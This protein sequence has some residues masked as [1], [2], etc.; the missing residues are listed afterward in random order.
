MNRL[1]VG[2]FTFAIN[3]IY[4]DRPFC[5]FY[6][7][8]TVGRVSYFAL[9]S[10]LDFYETLGWR[11]YENRLKIHFAESW[12]E[13]HHILIMEELSEDRTWRD[14]LFARLLALFYYWVTVIVYLVNPKSAHNLVELLEEFAYRSYDTFAKENKYSLMQQRAPQVALDYYHSGEVYLFDDFKTTLSPESCRPEIYN[15]YD[16]IIAI[17]NDE[18]EH[19]MTMVACQ[20]SDR[21]DLFQRLRHI[22]D[23]SQNEQNTNSEQLTIPVSRK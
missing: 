9:M 3:F 4:R 8:E 23:D 13:L 16:V 20:Q 1:F 7:L 19:F 10:V 17:R 22:I 12:N 14:R 15:L 5:R 11:H 21:P 6:V 18:L 2:A